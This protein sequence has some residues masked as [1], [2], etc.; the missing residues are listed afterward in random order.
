MDEYVR[1]RHY[2][3]SVGP[4]CSQHFYILAAESRLA[5]SA[6][7]LSTPTVHLPR[8]EPGLYLSS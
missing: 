3:M 5:T 8:S 6:L 1:V 2:A 7:I 4:D